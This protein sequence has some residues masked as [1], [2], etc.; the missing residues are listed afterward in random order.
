MNPR[1]ARQPIALA[2]F[3]L[4]LLA[5][6]TIPLSNA[7]E[8]PPGRPDL[9]TGTVTVLGPTSCPAGAAT[10]AGCKSVRVSCAGLPDLDAT[11]GVARPS[12]T[13][14]GTIILVNGGP[15]TTFLNDGFAD[16]YVN[17]GF[18]VVQLAWASDWAS[19]N[20]AGVKSAACRPASIFK[21]AFD[22][23]QQRSRTIGFCGQ[24]ISGG[25]AA[26]AY[27]LAEYGMSNYFDYV[28]LAASP[29]VSRMDYG[30][31]PS[32]YTGGPRNLCPLLTN[33][34]FAYPS[35]RKI[36]GWE[37]TTTC[38]KPNPLPS[39]IDRWTTDSIVTTGATYNYPHTAMSWFFCATPGSITETTGQGS[40]LTDQVV[41]LNTPPDANCYSGSC[42][43]ENP[44]TDKTAFNTTLN[45]MLSMC[46]P[47]H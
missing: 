41:P 33:A 40:F 35:G 10:G 22:V 6:G 15:G 37:G 4:M 14:S 25:G 32:L 46:V 26:L 16:T 28:A 47:N 23:V 12:G 31:D 43:G 27:A 7:V 2:F 13:V 8:P 5:P 19:A 44:W 9:P 39:D 20:D 17:D 38:A 18:N 36:D 45:E 42:Q 34:P 1:F 29:G 30:C 21:Y 3:V 24:G 11:L